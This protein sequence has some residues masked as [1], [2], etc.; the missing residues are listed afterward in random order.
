MQVF[1]QLESHH[2]LEITFAL[3][4]IIFVWTVD[5]ELAAIHVILCWFE[6]W[7]NVLTVCVTYHP[8]EIIT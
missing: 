4:W 8:A 7:F 6:T 5:L 2:A 3:T 1:I